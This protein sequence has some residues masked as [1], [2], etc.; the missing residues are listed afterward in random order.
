MTIDYLREAGVLVEH[1]QRALQ[2]GLGDL[3]TVPGT[4]KRIIKEKM[5]YE[6]TDPHSGRKYGPFTSFESF[7]IT[8][9]HSGGL[10]STIEQLRGLCVNDIEARDALDQATQ[11]VGGSRTDLCDNIP[12]VVAAPS[13]TSEAKALR[14]L[15][16]DR[17]D[18]HAQVL[19]EELSAHAAMIE[20]GFRPKTV[21]VRVTDP[22]STANTLRRAMAAEDLIE[23]IRL[24]RGE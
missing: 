5:W 12:E 24:L 22:A 1:L 7:V 23:L 8:P 16:K 18:L 14:R 15:R 17:P 19:A 20:A 2:N 9:T 6:R 4:L 13:G 10:G 3:R 11:H 21:S